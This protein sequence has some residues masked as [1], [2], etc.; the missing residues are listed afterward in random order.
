VFAQVKP[1]T[2]TRIDLGFVLGD[3]EEV[4]DEVR[5]WLR[6]AYEKDG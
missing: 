6:A 2:R 5:R 1:S 4:D 3:L